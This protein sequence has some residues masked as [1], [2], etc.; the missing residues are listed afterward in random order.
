MLNEKNMKSF[1]KGGKVIILPADVQKYKKIGIEDK[2]V[3]EA[4]KDVG[5]QGINF[6]SK[7]LL[8]K[9]TDEFNHLIESYTNYIISQDSVSITNYINNEIATKKEQGASLQEIQ[10]L[11]SSIEN[12]NA[13]KKIIFDI[14]ETQKGTLIQWI[15]YLPQSDYPSAFKYLILKAVL[16]YNYDLKQNKIYERG[17]ETIRNFTPFDAGSLSELYDKKSDFLLLD[18]SVLMNENSAKVLKSQE[19]IEETK[20]GKWIKF[21]GGKNTKSE[22]IEKN[23]KELM[24][25]VQNTYWC[26]KSAGTSQLRG[27]DF[28]VYVTE[29]NGEIFPRIAVRMSGDNVGEVRGNMSS[30][31]DIDAEMLPIAESFLN[32]NIPNDSGKK[33]LDS[34]KYNKKCVELRKKIELE[35]LYEN[36]IYDFIPIIADKDKYRVDYG[37][38]GNV[39]LLIKTFEELKNKLPNKYYNKS[40]LETDFKSLNKNTLYFIGDL[41]TYQISY[42]KSMFGLDISELNDWK[43]KVIS[44]SLDCSDIITD[45]GNLE[46]VGENLILSES[47]TDLGKLKF[48]GNELDLGK[49]N[50]KSLNN[51]EHIGGGLSVSSDIKDLGKLKRIGFLNIVSCADGF[52]LGNLEEIDNDLVI[53]VYDKNIDLGKLKKIGGRLIANKTLITDL[54]E[55]EYVGKDFQING[56]KIKIFQNLKT[57]GGDADFSNNFTNSTQN[58]ETILGSVKFLNSRIVEFNKLKKI[59][60]SI[61][62]KGSFFKTFGSIE[63][64]GGNLNLADSKIEELGNLKYVGGYISFKGS[65]VVFLNKLETITGFA[66]FDMSLVEDLGMLKSIGGNAYFNETKIK[67]IG[68][69][70]YI[71]GFYQFRGNKGLEEQWLKKNK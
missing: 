56:S 55:L 31:Q 11:E 65:K 21:K 43:L 8:K 69:L 29:L 18:Y 64:I 42:L 37:E 32:N 46:Y 66:N 52:T 10:I 50:I 61:D 17:S 58:I 20:G 5:L 54:K 6:D 40:D 23:G 1:A 38:N 13:R 19:I 70:E 41:G 27:G 7:S 25:L 2:Y 35:G 60:G 30:A 24:K 15:D 68:K 16:N 33:W 26:T 57:I 39:T 49:S 14:A 22:D 45:L 3:I 9:I 62:F 48:I 4:S 59:G 36:F 63:Y 34:I 44:K 28:Y 71:G 67:S 53:N 47:T 51:L 12:S